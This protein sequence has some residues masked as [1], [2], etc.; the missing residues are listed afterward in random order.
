MLQYDVNMSDVKITKVIRLG[1]RGQN[2][3]NKPRLILATLN[4]LDRRRAI[5]AAARTLRHTDD[6]ANIYIS[7]DV[8]PLER[9]KEKKLREELKTWRN[10]GESNLIIKGDKLVTKTVRKE[11]ANSQPEYGN[12]VNTTDEQLG[13]VS[14]SNEHV[15]KSVPKKD[16]RRKIWTTKETSGKYRKKQR[17]W[18]Q[19]QKSK[20]YM[21]CVRATNDKNEF[22]TLVR[23][24]SR[25]FERNLEKTS[26][27]TRKEFW[28]YCKSKLK[29]KSRLGDLQTMD[30]RLTSDDKVEKVEDDKICWS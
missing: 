20:N 2:K 4:N 26:N 3:Q 16:G 25:N 29:S 19:Y 14:N 10:A 15:P 9:E 13:K 6:W 21:D 12:V 18:K 5:L 24:L 7:P 30:G 1:G 23:N 28:G 27:R 17:A 8:T 22:T 11:L